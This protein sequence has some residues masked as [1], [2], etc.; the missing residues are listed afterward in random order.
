MQ[1]DKILKPEIMVF[2][3][4]WS[5]SCKN[6]LTRSYSYKQEVKIPIQLVHYINKKAEITQIK[7]SKIHK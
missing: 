4:F 7:Y 3:D 1:A 6:R 2:A 5:Y